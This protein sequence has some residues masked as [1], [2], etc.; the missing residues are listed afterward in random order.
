MSQ[1][2]AARL[3]E[4]FYRG[5]PS[6]TR[7]TGGTGLGLYLALLVARAHGGSLQLTNPG[8]HGASFEVRIPI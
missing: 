8:E 2:Q 1:E 6:R 5:D 3:G 4:A 7:E